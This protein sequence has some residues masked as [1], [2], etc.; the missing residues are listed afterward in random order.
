VIKNYR[1][2]DEPEVINAN[3]EEEE[4]HNLPVLRSPAKEEKINITLC[5]KDI[6]LKPFMMNADEIDEHRI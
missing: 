4:S 2:S 1:N 3:E 5:A 6:V